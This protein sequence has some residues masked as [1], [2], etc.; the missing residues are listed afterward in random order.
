MAPRPGMHYQSLLPSPL[1]GVRESRRYATYRGGKGAGT[2]IANTFAAVIKQ[3]KETNDFLKEPV[4]KSKGTKNH[5]FY[6]Y[7]L[8][9]REAQWRIL[10][11]RPFD[12]MVL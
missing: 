2:S 12:M 6:I 7:L 8:E 4:C 1:T 11:S 5:K 9:Y 3:E 10:K